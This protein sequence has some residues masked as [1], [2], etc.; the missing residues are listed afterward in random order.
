MKTLLR[1][2]K[3]HPI[4]IRLNK[5]MRNLIK[6]AARRSNTNVSTLIRFAIVNQLDEMERTGE[7]R[8][9]TAR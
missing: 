2:E 8:V 5:K 6:D 3:T 9:T 4:P 7:L 1:D